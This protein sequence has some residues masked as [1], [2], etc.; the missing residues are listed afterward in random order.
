MRSLRGGPWGV[1]YFTTPKKGMEMKL[2]SRGSGS[3]AGIGALPRRPLFNDHALIVELADDGF[4][5]AADHGAVVGRGG[6]GFDYSD[7]TAVVPCACRDGGHCL[8]EIGEAQRELLAPRGRGAKHA[9]FTGWAGILVGQ[10]D[11]ESEHVG[12]DGKKWI[13]PSRRVMDIDIKAL[14]G[15]RD[16][17]ELGS[18][19]VVLVGRGL[20]LVLSLGGVF[21]HALDGLF[22]FVAG[23]ERE[24][25]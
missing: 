5:I 15:Q 19:L 7:D 4:N 25:Q 11:A 8:V 3:K 1:G 24:G 6:G 23:G 22:L 17:V 13:G 10:N 21:G 14:G 12:A 9:S 18:L 2:V 20:G 16:Q